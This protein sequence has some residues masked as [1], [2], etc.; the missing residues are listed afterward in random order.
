MVKVKNYTA[1]GGGLYFHTWEIARM[2][3]KGIAF[4][5]KT[6]DLVW[7][8]KKAVHVLVSGPGRI[9][10]WVAKWFVEKVDK[11]YQQIEPPRVPSH[12]LPTPTE[13][14]QPS[15]FNPKAHAR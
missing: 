13:K 15:T 10:V 12:T 14:R 11:P 7:F 1:L 6:G 4:R 3:K 2:T 9:D 5:L 8:P